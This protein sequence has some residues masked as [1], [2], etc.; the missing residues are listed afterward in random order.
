MRSRDRYLLLAATLLVLAYA[1]WFARDK[2]RILREGELTLFELQSYGRRS[3]LRGDYLSLLYHAGDALG[4]EELPPS[5]YLIFTRD[6]DGVARFERVQRG[7]EPLTAGERLIHVR[8]RRSGGIRDG[9]IRLGPEQYYIEEGT[10]DRYLNARY[11]GLRI[12]E[13]G[14][15]VLEGLW[16]ANRQPIR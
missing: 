4:R 3:L 11:G 8:R 10:A 14:E 2:G 12:D 16:D 9:A 7:R 15:A 5:G 6:G 1:F 13:R